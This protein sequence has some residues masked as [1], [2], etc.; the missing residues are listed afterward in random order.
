VPRAASP[1]AEY[2]FVGVAKGSLNDLSLR[3][4]STGR[5]SDMS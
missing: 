2:A 1:E 4:P 3:P 5:K